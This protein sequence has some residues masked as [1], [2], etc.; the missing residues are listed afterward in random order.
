MNEWLN[1]IPMSLGAGKYEF[2]HQ[3]DTGIDRKTA[4]NDQALLQKAKIMG[5]G[6]LPET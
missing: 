1:L 2:F 6:L 5:A 4:S 3:Y